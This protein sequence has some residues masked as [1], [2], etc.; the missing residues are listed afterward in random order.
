MKRVLILGG[1]G[2]FGARLSRRLS[3]A[4]WHVIVAGRN[5]ETAQH[6]AGLLP[7][8]IAAKADRNADLQPLLKHH[9]PLLLI[10]AAGPFQGSRYHVAEACIEAGIAYLDL[11]DARDF[12]ANIHVLNDRAE[13]A[14]IAVISGAS[15]V[16]ALSG[17]I[18]QHLAKDYSRV[19]AIEM[20]ISAS[21]KAAAG[22]S[23][24]SAILSYVGKP[25]QLWTGHDW[26]A[27]AGWSD[28]Q[29]ER[30]VIP[31]KAPLN[32]LVALADI[33]DH[34][35]L[36]DRI[37][38]KPAVIFRAGPEF[39]FQTWGLW[40][41]AWGVRIGWL[42]SLSGLSGVAKKLQ[43]WLANFGS[44][45]SAMC[46]SLAGTKD[47]KPMRTRWTLIAEDG[48]GPEIPVMAA[49][50]LAECIAAKNIAAGACDAGM[51]L[52]LEQFE[53]LFAELAITTHTEENHNTPLYQR[54]MG[55]TFTRLP[56]IVQEMHTVNGAGSATGKAHVERG[57]SIIAKGICA[58]MSF[59]HSGEHILTVS[60]RE[61]EGVECW[62]RRFSGKSFSSHLSEK[63]GALLERFGPLRFYID[64]PSSDEGLSM[65]IQRWS[66]FH[67]PL[68]LWLAPRTEAHEWANGND[69]CLDITIDL[70]LIGRVIRYHGHL[71]R[72]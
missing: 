4:G 51:L 26:S 63:N 39:A 70:P 16:P 1:Y 11:A 52:G 41:L 35:L 33:P 64:L 71:R 30:F 9:K 45:R 22:L 42:R 69:F 17:A 15:S 72:T 7:N 5:L 49:Q 40:L 62:E 44:D 13:A 37:I 36:P 66:F 29:R 47:G 50:L 27:R 57:Q 65:A 34:V 38:G 21:S 25:M 58:L 54:I 48:D 31:G 53:P 59:P 3:A 24:A 19:N 12:V 14:G 60:F 18:L 61:H 32:R 10:D 20:A 46:V 2:G 43:S 8:A 67:V 55:D 28:L 68:P 23:V 56:P 6:L